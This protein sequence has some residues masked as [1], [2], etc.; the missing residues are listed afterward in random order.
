M[1]GCGKYEDELLSLVY[2]ELDDAAAETLHSHAEGCPACAQA[3]A[4]MSSTRR[5][6][7]QII[8]PEVPSK[9]DTLIMTEALSSVSAE[10]IRGNVAAKVA[11]DRPGF[12]ESLKMLLLHPAFAGAAVIALLVVTTV[13]I[14][15]RTQDSSSP[16]TTVESVLAERGVPPSPPPAPAAKAPSIEL[17]QEPMEMPS[18]DP[19]PS[20]GALDYADKAAFADEKIRGRSAETK[21][22]SPAKP[23]FGRE[24]GTAIRKGSD[25][26]LPKPKMSDS[27]ESGYP[28]AMKAPT[29]GGAAGG[30]GRR[31]TPDKEEERTYPSAR[32]APSSPPK[33]SY[34]SDM[35]ALFPSVGTQPAFAPPPLPEKAKSRDEAS[36]F[37]DEAPAVGSTADPASIEEAPPAE[38]KV[39]PDRILY[40]EPTE[41]K[42]RSTD[43]K[44]G[45]A[46]G[47]YEAGMDAYRRGDCNTAIVTLSQVVSSPSL[48]PG[49]VPSA[50]H[51]IARCEKRTGRC[52]AAVGH[53]DA[54]LHQYPSYVDRP[55]ALY[56]AAACYK[57]LGRIDKARE[58]LNTLR[59]IPGFES[60]AEEALRQL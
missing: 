43:K 39:A 4:E 38:A 49:K 57:R 20:Q 31:S 42:E 48:Y 56:E 40:S 7:A 58:L 59:S 17:S 60:R 54:L 35:D 8:H 10:Q 3:V 28:K 19:I 33:K 37:D 46:S 23:F 2:G 29:G 51:H 22:A 13:F 36:V 34:S 44:N 26:A 9:L 30:F 14:S 45:Q 55:N 11:A 1:N 15:S 47:A 32:R 53:L 41:N 24:N 18:P 6:S 52:A 25:E 27:S 5:I 16:K 50:L 12:W 21:S